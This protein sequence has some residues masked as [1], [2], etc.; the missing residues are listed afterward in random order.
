MGGQKL[1]EYIEYIK[2]LNLLSK[3]DLILMDENGTVFADFIKCSKHKFI[4]K[5]RNEA[6]KTFVE[7]VLK[8]TGDKRLIQEFKNLC[9]WTIIISMQWMCGS[10]KKCMCYVWDRFISKNT[11][12]G[13]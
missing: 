12:R 6:R 10:R 7:Q 8:R 4:Q 3:L 5:R 9:L 2:N 1:S 13:C 11:L